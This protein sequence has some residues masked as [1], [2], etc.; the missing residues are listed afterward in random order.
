MEAPGQ[1]RRSFLRTGLIAGGALAFGP[2]FWRSALSAAPATPAAGPYGPL[3]P[4]DANGIALPQGF[5]ARAIAQGNQPVQGTAY[6][7]H[8]FSD[9]AATYGTEDGGW[10]LV[11]NSEVPSA[12]SV[13]GSGGA[14]AIR[15]N[16]DGSIAD[17][18]R[19]LGGT[20][21]N[22]AGGATPWGTW[23]S[24]EEVDDGQV[25]ECDPRGQNPAVVHP[26]MGRFSHEAVAVDAGGRRVYLSEDEGESGF[27]RYTPS[28]WPDLS[29]GLLEIATV[30]RDG[31]VRW[32][33]VPDPSAASAPTRQQVAGSTKFH[34][35]E[36]IWF[37]NGIVYLA[38]TS[39][40]KIHAYDTA[41]E[42]IEV[43]YDGDALQDPP[44]K[45]VDNITVSRS[46]DLFV[47]EDNSE[48]SY[49]I[50]IITPD[51]KVSRFLTISGSQHTEGELTGVIFDPSGTRMYVAQQR[52]FATGVVYE[53]TGPFRT[54]RRAADRRRPGLTVKAPKA[55]SIELFRRRSL[56]AE[57]STD[58]PSAVTL[59]LKAKLGRKR[60]T[61]AKERRRASAVPRRVHVRGRRSAKRKLRGRRRVRAEL[62]AVARDAVG[63]RTTVKRKVELR[64]TR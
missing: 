3:G 43:L 55:M 51:R 39:D 60:V 11:S 56:V 62:Q 61:L 7:W 53:I 52:A 50:G 45:M 22:C 19:I 9:G 42:T 5:S 48:Q 38:T 14:S 1:T 26:A 2:A 15:F 12:P 49:D 47:C 20:R 21:T 35:G 30:G 8:N 32:S 36:G 57:V 16:A 10:I 13:P 27:Y 59:E 17:A 28:R 23:L 37:D 44:L 29:A 41:T 31:I 24:C 25:W 18:Y 4:P 6:V 54:D 46:G 64:S 58:E 34:R 33:R 63:N 40:S